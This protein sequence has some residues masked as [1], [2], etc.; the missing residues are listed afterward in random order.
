MKKQWSFFESAWRTL[1]LKRI[2]FKET[3]AGLKLILSDV[4][5]KAAESA[6]RASSSHPKTEEDYCSTMQFLLSSNGN[7][8]IWET[9]ESSLVISRLVG[10]N[11][12]LWIRDSIRD[13]MK[14]AKAASH[15]K[16]LTLTAQM[17]QQHIRTTEDTQ[18]KNP[19]FSILQPSIGRDGSG[20]LSAIP[21]PIVGYALAKDTAKVNAYLHS[22]E[23]S[24]ELPYQ[25]VFKWGL[26]AE[27][28]TA[29]ALYGLNYTK[30]ENGGPAMVCNSFRDVSTVSR[31][32]SSEG[33]EID[34]V[35]TP[36]DAFIWQHITRSVT[37]QCIAME[38]GDHVFS[39]PRVNGEIPNGRSSITGSFDGTEADAL[40]AILKNPISKEKVSILSHSI[41][42][43]PVK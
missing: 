40:V 15:S 3:A 19:L 24:L 9:F 27:T 13:L 26:H 38:M 31:K 1:A 4:D 28:A 2:S 34:M 16:D 5:M 21:G 29:F 30:R 35:M 23:A 10:L 42:V 41:K 12:S 33:L 6:S 7:F 25:Y 14:D 8:H 22:H 39:A 43:N 37:G 32:Q 17:Q 18:R 20:N 36:S 11:H